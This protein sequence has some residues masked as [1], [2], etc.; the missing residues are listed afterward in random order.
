MTT[1]PLL[2]LVC[3]LPLFLLTIENWGNAVLIIGGVFC[4]VNLIHNKQLNIKHSANPAL[5]TAFVG[6]WASLFTATLAASLMRTPMDWA[7]LDS[8]LRFI[9]AIP[10]FIFVVQ[11][12]SDAAKILLWFCM[13]AIAM[14]LA[15]Q[16]VFPPEGN[17]GGAER[18]S[19]RFADPLTYG[20]FCLSLGLVIFFSLLWQPRPQAKA[21]FFK[22]A[23]VGLALFM[24]L[25]TQSRT[26]WI[27]VPLLALMLLCVYR[28]T[29]T[30]GKL[31]LY[32]C[33]AVL[34]CSG[35]WLTSSSV[36]ERVMQT[37]A[38]VHQYS[39]DGTAPETSVGLRIT[40][41]RIAADMVL[42]HPL[43]GYGDTQIATLT[44]PPHVHTYA[45]KFAS[46]FALSSGFH[47]EIVTNGVQSGLLA[48]LATASLF[49]VPI[50]IYWRTLKVG[51]PIQK[52]AALAGLAFAVTLFISS[53]STEVFGLKY[54]TS[55]YALINAI[56]CGASLNTKLK[57]R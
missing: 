15:Y 27:A 53:L 32:W 23:F 31:F 47:N 42:E 11:Q 45:T 46:D 9:F 12:R 16:L 36:R 18:M 6:S 1:S 54:T 29:I 38:E 17:W 48:A 24:S 57:L 39:L 2:I 41:L 3:S 49:G 25:R 44:V 20:Y 8:P 26:G 37:I 10:V 56:L 5:A 55:F 43:Q 19:T 51:G 33:V 22:V 34:V 28:H 7:L 4:L 35:L 13:A 21:I 30:A 14:T 40:F 50:F 52:N